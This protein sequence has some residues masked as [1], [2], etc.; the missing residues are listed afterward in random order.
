MNGWNLYALLAT[1]GA[2]AIVPVVAAM[3]AHRLHRREQRLP[4]AT[5]FENVE[6]LLVERRTTLAKVET[7]LRDKLAAAA[8]CDVA[9]AE[10]QFYQSRVIEARQELETMASRLQEL[11]DL[12]RAL[13]ELR[14]DVVIARQ[15]KEELATERTELERTLEKWRAE[16]DAMGGQRVELDAAIQS[17]SEQK[18][19]LLAEIEDITRQMQRLGQENHQALETLQAAR[20]EHQSLL[21]K[22]SGLRAETVGLE[23]ALGPLR[24]QHDSLTE[25]VN[26]LVGRRDE[27]EQANRET[28]SRLRDIK[29]AEREAGA[30]LNRLKEQVIEADRLLTA[31][32]DAYQTL[33]DKA[34]ALRAE[35][36]GLEATKESL[37]AWIKGVQVTKEG[38]AKGSLDELIRPPTCFAAFSKPAT[39][40][41]DEPAALQRVEEH[42]T[43]LG[44]S[45]PRRVLYAF[46][47]CL[48]IA[49]ISPLTVL[50]GISGTGKSQLP[51]RYAEAMG[52]HFLP[53]A[54]QPRWDSPQ[55]LFG[56]YNYLEQRYK[57]TELARAMV[58]LDAGNWPEQAKGNSDRVVLTLLDEM[59]LAR[60]EYYFSEFLS[61]LEMR[62][63]DDARTAAAIDLELG[64]LPEDAKT[65]VYPVENFLFVGTMNEDE[66]TQTLS[67][68]V[69]DRANVFRFTRPAEL[70]TRQDGASG[71]PAQG[72][73]PLPVWRS[74]HRPEANDRQVAD[75]IAQLNEALDGLG[76]PFGHRLYQAI[77][78]YVGNHPDAKDIRGRRQAFAD[79]LE[80]RIFP[81]LR[82]IE[83]DIQRD[84]LGRIHRLLEELGDDALTRAFDQAC[85]RELF[86]W[87]GVRREA[88]R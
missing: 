62:H 14:E 31:A 4:A 61:K 12:K 6:S 34:N 46:H 70:A 86:V 83:P 66:T 19:T 43:S 82:G 51:R 41:S 63:G 81:K 78:A 33:T 23:T 38:L 16:I 5:A 37:A 22:A 40:E 64:K 88:E 77:L 74:W 18:R 75:W 80:L 30:D 36:A 8:Q 71:R 69:V 17:L 53:L 85:G 9:I 27:L 68:K 3:V 7:E 35:V 32:R 72:Y 76:R 50:A 25:R 15:Q 55:D 45:F 28:E 11:E 59:N 52:L 21:E 67:D 13:A 10:A 42:L 47:T 39:K 79:Q 56:F 24:Q 84:N 87:P 54:V 57:A 73:L 58:H 26:A 48:K 49:D 44:L 2:G 60:V 65:R 29:A 1:T 20:S